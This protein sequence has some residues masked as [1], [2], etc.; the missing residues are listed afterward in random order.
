MQALLTFDQAP[1][2]A[3]PFRFF[4][5]APLF[6][7]LAGVL[8]LWGGPDA[9]AS[10]WTPA[11]LALTHLVTAGFMLQVM[12]GAMVQVL[13]VVAGANIVRPLLVASV[14]HAAITLGALLLAAAFLSY[15]PWLFRLAV[16]CLG[17]GLAV[18]VAAAAHAL[19]GVPSTSPT[20]RGLKLSL[21]GLGVTAGLGLML[22]SALGWSLEL[23][24][25]QLADLHLGWGFVAWGVALLAAVAY[26]VVPMFQLTPA[27]P[28][29][30]SRGFSLAALGTVLLWTLADL[31]G[32]ASAS[33]LLAGAVVALAALFAG[34]TLYVQRRSKR[35]KFDATQ[36][37]WRVAMVSALAAGALWLGAR[38][39]APLAA[40]PAWPLLCGVLLLSGGFMSVMVGMLYKI[41]PFLV[42][43][44][45][46]NV[47][48]GRLAAPNM[49]KVL[50]ER[51]MN[52]QMAAHFSAFALLLLAV[53][54]P[55]WFVYPAGLAL[56]VANLWLLR[57]LLSA[58]GVYRQHCLKVEALIAAQAG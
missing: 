3:A 51:S 2:L 47:G 27:Y 21:L 39:F 52:R 23:P 45:L 54:W 33:A 57:N 37:Y 31:A 12:L 19:L 13:P 26:V 5:T 7:I 24:L 14:V 22:A 20:I 44:H 56:I 17:G 42:W 38:P 16:I 25:L 30:F 10:R 15:E 48:R 50:A 34:V 55:A 32:W 41:V 53:L 1:P 58:V 35:A 29:W 6:A 9:F 28:D 8:V 11:A 4:V 36:H 46:Q 49:K 18:F 43:M 40:W